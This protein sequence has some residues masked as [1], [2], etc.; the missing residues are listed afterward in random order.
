MNAEIIKALAVT[1][2]V[3]GGQAPSE[4]AARVIVERLDCYDQATV[5][6][7]LIRCQD[8]V[9]G[10]LALADILARIDDGR[11]GP[12][13][14]WALCPKNED[15]TVVWT[16][17]MAGAWG[18]AVNLSD[19]VAQRMA[20]LEAYKKAV[21]DARR[22]HKQVRWKPSLGHDSRQREQAVLEAYSMGRLSDGQVKNAI[23]YLPTD[24]PPKALPGQVKRILE[25]VKLA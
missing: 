2:E 5:F 11:P 20:F 7:A 6:D 21:A 10:R 8:E 1:F 23:G 13:E 18:C 15:D 24:E 9:K 17:E 12:E 14:A 16:D 3:C 22:N 4:A 19:R 25:L